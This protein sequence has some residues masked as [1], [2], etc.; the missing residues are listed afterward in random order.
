M[1][2]LRQF[3]KNEPTVSAPITP[4]QIEH[5][6]L[7]KYDS[8]FTDLFLAHPENQREY[9][10][11]HRKRHYELFNAMVYLLANQKHPRVLEAGVSGFLPLYKKISPTIR[12]VTIDRPIEAHGCNADYCVGVGGAEQHYNVDLTKTILAPEWGTPPMGTFDYIVFTE[13]LEHLVIN[14]VELLSSLLTLLNPNGYLYLSTPNF[15]QYHYLEMLKR[16]ENPQHIYP[17]RGDNWD[18]HHHFREYEMG[19]LIRFVGEAGGKVVYAYYSDCW[20]SPALVDSVLR[21]HPEQ[22]SNLV[23]VAQTNN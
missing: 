1:R 23:L 19:E 12:L 6:S 15:F 13:V 7:Q 10:T 17:R 20:D 4:L 14:P 21:L 22:K 5:L 16:R 2:L 18:A 8:L 3:R 9:F 11:F